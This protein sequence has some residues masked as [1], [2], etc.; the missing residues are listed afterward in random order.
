MACGVPHAFGGALALAYYAEPRATIDIDVNVFVPVDRADD[1]LGPLAQLGADVA[2]GCD[3]G[4]PGRTGPRAV[5][6]DRDR[7]VLLVR[8]LPRRAARAVCEVP[9]ADSTLP[10]LSAAHLTVCKVR[11]D[12]PK[13]WVDIDAMLA[14]GTSIDAAE[15]LRWVG[16][17][18]GDDDPRFDR[19][20]A[21]LSTSG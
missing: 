8:P 19:I 20:A 1:V 10:I 2:D 11:F 16:R 9:F 3:D 17:I 14:L 15:V 7:P 5:G 13:D 12:R 18:A 4:P 21:V 6:R